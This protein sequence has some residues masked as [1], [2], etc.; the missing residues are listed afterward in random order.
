MNDLPLT[1]ILGFHAFN[2]GDFFTAHELFEAAWRET[3]AAPREFFRALLLLSGGYFRLTQDRPDAAIKFFNRA[4][5][6][7]DQYPNPYL[8]IDTKDIKTQLEKLITAIQ[9]GAS[10]EAVLDQNPFQLSWDTQE[11]LL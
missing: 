2:Q 11:N 10:G 7:I 9:S 6:W 4:L 1:V 3:S 8:G 5:G